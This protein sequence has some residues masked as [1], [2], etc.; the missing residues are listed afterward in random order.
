LPAPW[1]THL[2]R[3]T[4]D[5]EPVHAHELL[6]GHAVSVAAEREVHLSKLS[7]RA[8]AAAAGSPYRSSLMQAEIRGRYSQVK[9]WLRDMLARR[10]YMLALG[11]LD[12]RRG[13]VAESGMVVATME[14]RVFERVQ[15]P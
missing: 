12:I 1:W 6:T 4:A 2:S 15:Q 11:S 7:F 8:Q 13:P 5:G 10:P 14:F 3:T 9:G